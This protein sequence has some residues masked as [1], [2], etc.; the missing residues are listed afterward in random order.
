M[1]SFSILR[2]LVFDN[3]R[4]VFVLGENRVSR[5]IL[6]AERRYAIMK[7]KGRMQMKKWLYLLAAAAVGIYDFWAIIFVYPDRDW[8]TGFCK[9]IC[10]AGT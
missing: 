3:G 5:E 10:P 9:D 7:R 1:L 2:R 4:K 8:K 6:P